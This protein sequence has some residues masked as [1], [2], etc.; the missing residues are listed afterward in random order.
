MHKHSLS[1]EHDSFVSDASIDLAG[2]WQLKACNRQVKPCEILLPG[3]IVSALF[4]NKIIPDPYIGENELAIQWV[5]QEDWL[6]SRTFF[7]EATRCTALYWTF[8]IDQLDTVAEI[9]INNKAIHTSDNAFRKYCIPLQSILE[10]GENS[11]E[12]VIYSPEKEA[13]IRAKQL[14]YEIPHMHAPVQS[15]HRNLIRK[16]QCHGGWDWGPCIMTGGVF[17]N[18]LIQGT[19]CERID[20]LYPQIHRETSQHWKVETSV[21]V[22][23]HQDSSQE[24][25]Y[26]ICYD[27][28][29]IVFAKEITE[30]SKGS[31]TISYCLNVE[32]PLLWRTHDRGDQPLYTLLV[33][34]QN[35]QKATTIAFRE[36]Y[37]DTTEDSHGKSFALKLNGEDL[38]CKGA[39]WIPPD[40]L[41]ARQTADTYEHLIHSTQAAHM[42]MLRVWGGGQYE[43]DLFYELCDRA[44]ILI[45]QDCMF[46]CSLYPADQ[47]FLQNVA[48]EIIYQVKRLMH[49]PCLALWCGN[50]EDIG[51]LS[52]FKASQENRD[53]YLVD[54]DRLNEGVI[55]RIVQQLDPTRLWWPSSPS[56]GPGDY[57]DCWH[58]SSRGD[59]HYWSVWH[60]G[61]PF[62]AY[63]TIVPRFCSE[64]GF[65]SFPS[66]PTVRSFCDDHSLNVTSPQMEHHQKNDRGN[67]IITE[68]LTRYFRMPHSFEHTLYL[69]QVQQAMAIE[70]AVDHWSCFPERCRG[71]LYWQLNDCW[72]VS[73]WSSIEYS[74]RWKLL[75]YFARRFFNPIRLAWKRTD[76]DLSVIGI[77]ET[78]EPLEAHLQIESIFF[79]G[80]RSSTC[81]DAP[82]HIASRSQKILATISLD[83][84][85]ANHRE[86]VLRAHLQNTAKSTQ[87][88]FD[89]CEKTLFLEH[90]KRC[91]LNPSSISLEQDRDTLVL[92][93]TAPAFYVSLEHPDPKVC[94]S[95]NGFHLYPHATKTITLNKMSSGIR[96]DKNDI[97]IYHLR[98]SYA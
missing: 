23:A 29:T 57:S 50:N 87:S 8:C 19:Q 10:P 76:T 46:A 15:P 71:F 69:S 88:S 27:K 94:F 7:L 25:E 38:L 51:A 81:V 42:N 74:G 49:H 21:D 47:E 61:L 97:K 24:I 83:T 75:H 70:K 22:Y 37:V 52:W 77:N 16:T 32:D 59:M 63:E 90:P 64:F 26:S 93:S 40:A 53:V 73:S 44:G 66:L 12:I 55:G 48:D 13:A 4:A 30:L 95:D 67:T 85:P 43:H 14:P 35:D 82:V 28:K 72:P 65:Q 68:T 33:R 91:T 3:D 89:G 2:A 20:A 62:E 1:S 17:G 41:P 98:D 78:S 6:L 84:L 86:F 54:Y 11:I 80:E 60:E 18:I 9:R 31:N 56:A 5:G 58:D 92:Q 79:S 96:I 36:I 39:N 45:W 34:T